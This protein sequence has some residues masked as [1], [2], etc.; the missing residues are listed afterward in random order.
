M[1]KLTLCILIIFIATGCQTLKELSN[2]IAK[3]H[4][5][6]ANVQV[7]DFTFRNIQLAYD[8]K[9][10]NPN[11]FSLHMLSYDYDLKING[12]NFIQGNHAKPVDIAA[13]GASTFQIP[14][15]INFIDLYRL[16]HSLRN[17]DRSTYQIS[18]DLYFNLPVLGKTK[19][20]L[21]K[22]GKLPLLKLP[23]VHL[24]SIHL[25]QFSL[26][27]TKL[28]LKLAIDNP[29]GFA[30]LLNNLDY[31]LL[32]NGQPW[33]EA[34]TARQVSINKN[35]QELISI[36]ISLNLLQIGTSAI[37][38]LQS[39]G[40]LHYRFKGNLDFGIAQPLFEGARTLFHVNQKGLVPLRDCP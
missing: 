29:N 37:Q 17:K 4:V 24:A 15:D 40:K 5:S 23:N 30:L 39:S 2:N 16:F 11:P 31:Q 35:G 21:T 3:P 36:P 20:P 19:I 26:R 34:S 28:I 18:V 25:G 13:A 27:H 6:V 10:H 33:V 14:V 38:L 8:I 7:T 22:Q 9:V 1:K 32:I 12:H